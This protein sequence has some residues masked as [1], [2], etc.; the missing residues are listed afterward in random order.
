M[1]DDS[2]FILFFDM[3]ESLFCD[4]LPRRI[5]SKNNTF[6]SKVLTVLI[7]L[8][9]IILSLAI[10]IMIGIILFFVVKSIDNIF[11]AIIVIVL[12]LA[13][14]IGI[15]ILLDVMSKRLLIFD[16]FADEMKF[17]KEKDYEKHKVIGI[18]K[19]TNKDCFVLSYFYYNNEIRP[20]I[21]KK[22]KN[23]IGL[24]DLYADVTY[25]KT[26][27]FDEYD[28]S[29]N[30]NIRIRR[31]KNKSTNSQMIV[32]ASAI[33]NLEIYINDV[34]VPEIDCQGKLGQFSVYAILE[35]ADENC[36]IVNINGQ[37]YS[38]AEKLNNNIF[39]NIKEIVKERSGYYE[40]K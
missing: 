10:V 26:I 19:Q 6:L 39:I 5:I 8:A 9:E 17:S 38:L 1:I 22:H 40:N 16:S 34:K 23:S 21:Y 14:L 4:V 31:I 11:I 30:K 25:Y 29:E 24:I 20:A 36:N 28:L 12:S 3:L 32:F 7:V 13:A 37:Q 2:I 15:I 27:Y 18:L 33:K 35:N